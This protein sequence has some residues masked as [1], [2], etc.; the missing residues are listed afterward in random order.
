M[1][2]LHS[3]ESI[4]P[5]KMPIHILGQMFTCYCQTVSV[6]QSKPNLVHTD[7]RSAHV[8]LVSTFVTQVPY[9]LA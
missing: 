8:N 3:N 9:C 4:K 5:E 2:E 6:L 1:P 7:K